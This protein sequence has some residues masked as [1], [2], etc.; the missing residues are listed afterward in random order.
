MKIWSNKIFQAVMFI[1]IAFIM[2]LI[3]TKVSSLQFLF[4]NANI[5]EGLEATSLV[6]DTKLIKVLVLILG[7]ISLGLYGNFTYSTN[8]KD[9]KNIL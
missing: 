8:K 1:L 4:E 2:G 5:L 3:Y 6:R 9:I 7:G